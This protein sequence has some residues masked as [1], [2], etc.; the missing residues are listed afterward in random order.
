MLKRLFTIYLLPGIV[1]QS[2]IV[3]GGYAT[4]QELV[5]YFLKLGPLDGLLAMGVT[6]TVWSLL[7]AATFLL[8]YR[9]KAYD[10][11][12]LLKHLLG[13]G[14][15]L[16][17]GCY[18]YVIVLVLSIISITVA[19]LLHDTLNMP[20][21]VG[22]LLCLAAI[23]VISL[24]SSAL[25][26]KAFTFWTL[27]LYL[28]FFV[29]LVLSIMKSNTNVISLLKIKQPNWSWIKNGI[30]YA[31]YNAAALPAVVFAM[32]HV[33]SGK[34]ATIAGLL[35]GP[36]AMVP[37]IIFYFAL[38]TDHQA[39]LSVM[40]P[41]KHLLDNLGYVSLTILFTIMLGGT[42]I[43]TGVGLL[44]AFYKRLH[45]EHK[46]SYGAIA[47]VFVAALMTQ[48]GL[49]ELIAKG[50]TVLSWITIGVFVIPLIIH[51]LRPRLSQYF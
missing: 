51:S 13:R 49:I 7:S 9:I 41:S 3:A 22:I 50:Y 27:L 31:C 23:F 2:I 28:V 30:I 4:G 1:F 35:A 43:Q 36:I 24:K 15:I 17:E 40:I 10:Y 47:L 33:Q 37:G 26:E 46:K 38:L 14:W 32:R 5:Q 44:H 29:I 34:Q 6:L 48:L 12:N 11:K 18:I 42:L 21:T 25:I 16:Y 45:V 19:H 20:L 39:V 8:A